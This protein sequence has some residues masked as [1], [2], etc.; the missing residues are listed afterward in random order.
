M[1]TKAA[2]KISVVMVVKSIVGALTITRKHNAIHNKTIKT[3]WV[4]ERG[5]LILFIP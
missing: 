1:N 5:F 4:F 2:E 3:I